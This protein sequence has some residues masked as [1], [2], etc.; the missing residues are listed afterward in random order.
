[1]KRIAFVLFLLLSFTVVAR[2]QAPP[3]QHFVVSTTA[4]SFE[5]SAVAI[6]TLGTQITPEVSVA[7]E[8]ISNP[9]DSSKPHIGS[10]VANYTLQLSRIVPAKIRSKLLIDLSN[11]NLTFQAGAGV[12]SLFNGAGTSRKSHIVGNF[13]LY[14]SYPLPGG[15][16]QISGGIKWIVG[17]QGGLVKVPSATLNFTF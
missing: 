5:G 1:M 3:V 11:Y 14:P 7:Y 12:E 9:A 15:H 16:S 13:G 4:G 8:F 17:P 10:G 2:G 6:A